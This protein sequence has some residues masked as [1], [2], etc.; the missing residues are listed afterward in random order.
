M[1]VKIRNGM[2]HDDGKPDEGVEYLVKAWE[3]L[4]DSMV[5]IE[6]SDG[7][8]EV[9]PF[10]EGLKVYLKLKK[11][12]LNPTVRVLKNKEAAKVLFGKK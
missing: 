11:L 8:K 6:G 7:T 10:G 12:N 9:L 2:L 5:L 4:M 1:A 3:S